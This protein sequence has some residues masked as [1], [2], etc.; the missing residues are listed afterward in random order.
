MSRDDAGRPGDPMEHLS[1]REEE[2]AAELTAELARGLPYA[3]P[4]ELPPALKARLLSIGETMVRDDARARAQ[5]EAAERTARPSDPT[6]R[7]RTWGGWLAA[8]AALLLWVLVPRAPRERVDDTAR[9]RSELL[10]TAAAVSTI[11]WTATTDSTAIGASGDVVWSDARQRGVMRFVGLRPNDR[12]RYQ[13]QLWI[14]DETRDKAYPVDGGV[15]DVPA[16]AS[17]VLVPID[18]RVPV[19]KAVLFAITVEPPGGVVVSTRER[20]ALLAERKS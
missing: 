8:A 11:A 1:R 12:A 19:G 18:A 20:I 2:A 5:R 16:G 9:L 14:F 13:Y 10:A 4:D 15:F 7:F 3:E 17:E 6:A